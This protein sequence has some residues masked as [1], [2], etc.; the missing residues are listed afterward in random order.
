MELEDNKK[1]SDAYTDEQILDAY[2]N[3]LDTPTDA[4]WAKIEAGLDNNTATGNVYE[5]RKKKK[6]FKYVWGAV[7]IAAIIIC[8]I[9]VL[10]FVTGVNQKSDSGLSIK[11]D[12]MYNDMANE[13]DNAE[14]YENNEAVGS[15]DTEAVTES[16]MDISGEAVTGNAAVA[17]A[18]IRIC[19]IRDEI[20]I[21]VVE[22]TDSDAFA[23]LINKKIEI[24]VIDEENLQESSVGEVIYGALE[25]DAKGGYTFVQIK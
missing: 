23:D 10:P 13:S 15:Y 19:E 11:S 8:T 22:D 21:G 18:H 4:I 20:V 16:G 24:T 12:E 25:S 14:S 17:N 6:V 9:I 5:L 7:G 3:N 1:Y 2:L